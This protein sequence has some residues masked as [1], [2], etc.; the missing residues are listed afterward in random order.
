MLLFIT[1]QSLFLHRIH[2]RTIECPNTPIEPSSGSFVVRHS[3]FVGRSSIDLIAQL[4][5]VF[6]GLLRGLEL[7]CGIV[8][9]AINQGLRGARLALR[10]DRIEDVVI[11]R[12]IQKTQVLKE[13]F[14]SLQGRELVS[15]GGVPQG[16]GVFFEDR[17]RLGPAIPQRGLRQDG[18]DAVPFLFLE[19]CRDGVQLA[20]CLLDQ[21]QHLLDVVFGRR[22]RCPRRDGGQSRR[23]C[24]DTTPGG[25]GGCGSGKDSS[26]S[27]GCAVI[28]APPTTIVVVVVIEMLVVV[29]AR[30]GSLQ[31]RNRRRCSQLDGTK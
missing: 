19:Q 27:F 2:T 1:P 31:H 8:V 15:L 16:L 11:D 18:P 10:G 13:V 21:I 7:P 3:S 26:S 12:H 29:V 24:Q 17:G 14:P 23:C 28:I 6:Y 4:D 22:R 20:L 25:C 9:V 5:Q 30:K